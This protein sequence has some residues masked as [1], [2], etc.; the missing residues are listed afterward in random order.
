[1]AR[2]EAWLAGRAMKAEGYRLTDASTGFLGYRRSTFVKVYMF[3]GVETGIFV[4]GCKDAKRIG[5]DIYNPKG[6]YIASDNRP[7]HRPYQHLKPGMT[8]WYW[9][10]VNMVESTPNGAH[11]SVV[12]GNK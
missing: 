6:T 2:R 9:I 11:Y 5:I 4:A 3:K 12:L 7:T 8:G 1:Q 10:R